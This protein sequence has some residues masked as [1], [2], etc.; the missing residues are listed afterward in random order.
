ME[1]ELAAK[2]FR[3]DL[4]YRL[5]VFTIYVPPL[6]ERREEI[7]HLIEETIRRAPTEMK[8]GRDCSFCPRLMDAALRYEWR[9]NIRELRNFVTRT[10]ILRDQDAAVG[11]LEAKTAATI[12]PNSQLGTASARTHCS[13]M[14][15]ML[16]DVKD[17]TEARMI[18]DA[19]DA[20]GWNRRHA[21]QL[22]DIS[23]RSLLYKMQQHRLT[24]NMPGNLNEALGNGYSTQIN[25]V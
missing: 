17:R 13:G 2:T 3:E 8:S 16:R 12:E 19:L 25:A 22:L 20:S 9:G 5:G 4:Y 23:Y 14:R 11:E 10:I 6:R 7:R 1:S 24:P 21:A 15:S 18:Q